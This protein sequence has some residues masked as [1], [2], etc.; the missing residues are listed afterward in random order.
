MPSPIAE[1]P[2]RKDIFDAR[3]VVEGS[4]SPD[5][6]TAAYTLCETVG[7]GE[8]ARLGYSLWQVGTRSGRPKRLSRSQGD[9]MNPQFA[10]DGRLVYF[11]STR[12]GA[13]Q[14]FRISLDGGEAEQ[15]TDLPQGVLNFALSP[16]GK[17]IAFSAFAAPVD[18]S[19]PPSNKRITRGFYRMD[20]M[21]GYLQDFEQA[22]YQIP[23]RGGTP[24]AKTEHSGLIMQLAWSPNSDELAYTVSGGKDQDFMQMHLKVLQSDGEVRE[25]VQDRMISSFFWNLDGKRFGFLGYRDNN[26]ADISEVYVVPASGGAVECR[27][28]S[29]DLA[30]GGMVQINSPAARPS[31]KSHQIDGGAFAFLPAVVGGE[32]RIYR[33]ALHGPELLEPV[34]DGPRINLLFDGCG[35]SLLYSTQDCNRPPEL[36]IYDTTSGEERVLTQHNKRIGSR[37]AWP[38]VEHVKVM[39]APDTEIEGWVLTPPHL[40]PPYKTILY[41]HG[42]P[43]AA[44][45]LSFNIDF[46]EI[47]GAGYALAYCNPRGSV[48]YGGEFSKSIV[49]RWGEPESEDFHAFLDRLIELGIAD[50]DKLGVTGVSGGGHLSGWLIGHTDRFKAA[51]PEQGV[52][53]MFSMWGVSDAGKALI[54]LEMGGDPHE[55]PERYWALSPVAHAHKCK[56]PTLLIQGEND[57][58]CPMEQAEQMFSIIHHAGCEVEFLRLAN[59][60]HGLEIFGPP[61]LR[62]ARMDAMLEWFERHIS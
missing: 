47:V 40:E 14:I 54:N 48:G 1:P 19:A 4:L 18:P 10:P 42:G 11:L 58:R 26:L 5:G 17:R 21:P 56:T 62:I 28:L 50:G 29:A 16:D 9:E 35:T 24:K 59:C 37:V 15:V 12:T 49:E 60:S 52:Y 23:S 39:S 46:Q 3:F 33:V 43:H 51:V 34:I 41:I 22:I 44:F 8:T 2:S 6:E 32:I 20:G 38:G 31:H 27:T 55:C 7:K 61:A 13:P 36:A 53:N 30:F 57:I 25:V 45:G